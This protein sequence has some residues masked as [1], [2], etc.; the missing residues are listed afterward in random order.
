MACY[1]RVSEGRD[2]A[3]MLEDASVKVFILACWGHRHMDMRCRAGVHR[4]RFRDHGCPQSMLR[5]HANDDVTGR[6]QCVNRCKRR[7][8]SHAEFILSRSRFWVEL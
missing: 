4:K 8:R 2:G 3:Q 6:E 1:I 5:G 7:Q